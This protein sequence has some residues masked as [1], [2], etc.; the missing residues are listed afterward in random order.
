VFDAQPE[1]KT[2][3]YIRGD[4]RNPDK[5][6]ELA[7]GVPEALG[8]RF[9]DIGPVKLP[10]ESY[11]PDKRGFVIQ[12][13]LTA[14]SE[15]VQRA[16]KP[17][18][19]A[20]RKVYAGI[21]ALSTDPVMRIEQPNALLWTL[22]DFQL[23]SRPLALAHARVAAFEAVIAAERLA[24]DGKKGTPDWEAAARRAVSAQQEVLDLEAKILALTKLRQAW[25]APLPTKKMA[26]EE[27]PA[28]PAKPP[29]RPTGTNYIPRKHTTYPATSTGRRLAFARWIADTQNPLTARVAVNHIWLR[30][31][32]QPI[33]PSV[34]DFGRNGRRPSH[35]A[36]LDWLAAE[37][38]QPTVAGGGR[39]P[40]EA[41]GGHQPSEASGGRQPSEAWRFKHLHRLIVTSSTYR[42]ASTPDAKNAEL[43]RDNV[44]LWRMPSKRLEAELVRDSIL[45]VSGK[46]DPAMGGP[47]IDYNLG[48]TTPRRSLYFRHAQEKQMEFLKIFDCA[49]VTEC[50]QRKESVLPQQ[51]LAL[52]N[53][54][55]TR[56][57]ARLL[58]RLLHS[59]HADA[60]AFVTAAFEQTLTRTPSQAE[61]RECLD[62]LEQQT[63]RLAR[64]PK[65]AG[66]K[67]DRSQSS[68]DPALRAREDLVHVLLNHHDFVTIR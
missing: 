15:E 54:G 52:A 28:Q 3:L 39:Q 32:G 7:P 68:P 14:L 36:L 53:S 57:N 61:V 44:Y 25:Q 1:A 29:E 26:A 35:P 22:V 49:A 60:T 33:V 17:F 46:L 66:D 19:E 51:A 20:A 5:S 47:D 58:A 6:K 18:E 4:D 23:R 62:F 9:G 65:P 45:Y 55:L 8:G 12:E 21:T 42:M 67:G 27:K 50:Y 48:L 10:L 40:S 38:M 63:E 11:V 56:Q 2:Y 41:S 43:D 31:I 16:E 24:D 30:H 37:F 13:Q 59:R 34:F 64:N